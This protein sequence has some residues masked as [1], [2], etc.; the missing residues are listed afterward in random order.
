MG[1]LTPQES[2]MLVTN[3]I[4]QVWIHFCLLF[5]FNVES[6]G[7]AQAWKSSFPQTIFSDC[8]SCK[9]GPT[10]PLP[11]L[12]SCQCTNIAECQQI[13]PWDLIPLVTIAAPVRWLTVGGC[14]RS[15]HFQALFLL[16]NSMLS[17][18]RPQKAVSQHKI[19]HLAVNVCDMSWTGGCMVWNRALLQHP[20]PQLLTLYQVQFSIRIRALPYYHD[21]K[22]KLDVPCWASI[23]RIFISV[24]QLI[25]CID[26]KLTAITNLQC[27]V[28]W[29][30][31]CCFQ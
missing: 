13:W 31:C 9:A 29:V 6:Y 21:R 28:V 15:G 3:I 19:D 1:L 11:A 17:E 22:H 24:V 8:S 20:N 23:I 25:P 10:H 18:Q 5:T 27:W 14:Q 30:S 26:R 12:C 16:S 4:Q 7:R 2:G